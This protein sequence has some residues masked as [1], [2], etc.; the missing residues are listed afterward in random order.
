[1]RE[2]SSCET[3]HAPSPPTRRRRSLPISSRPRT[4]LPCVPSW[5]RPFVTAHRVR[6]KKI[7]D[8]VIKNVRIVRPRGD[9]VHEADIAIRDGRFAQVSSS[10]DASKAKR[11]YDG[12]KRLAFPGVVD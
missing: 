7:Y 11:V 4:A 2:R 10:I 8:L 12:K 3:P 9:A 6:M 1:M 5:S